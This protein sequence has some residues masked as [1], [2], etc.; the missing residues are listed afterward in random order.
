MF[1]QRGKSGKCV[2]N[3]HPKYFYQWIT[4]L[5]LF[6]TLYFL[7]IALDETTLATLISPA[8]YQQPKWVSSTPFGFLFCLQ[9]LYQND[10]SNSW[11]N[12][13]KMLLKPFTYIVFNNYFK[14]SSQDVLHTSSVERF[15]LNMNL[16]RPLLHSRTI[17]LEWNVN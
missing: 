10:S 11:F 2:T 13:S 16:S 4:Y 8:F 1:S 3:Y 7:K 6:T 5:K 15:L 14:I 12:I 9:V 17:V